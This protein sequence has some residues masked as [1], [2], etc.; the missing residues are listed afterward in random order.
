MA[1]RMGA[2]GILLAC[3]CLALV[4]LTCA[5]APTEPPPSVEQQARDLTATPTS[6]R[7]RTPTRTY[8]PRASFTPAPT[9]TATPIPDWPVQ[10]C[11]DLAV[12]VN[13]SLTEWSAVTPVVLNVANAAAVVL[14]PSVRAT[15]TPVP[16]LTPWV[17]T[18]TPTLTPVATATTRPTN[19]PAPAVADFSGLFYCAH[20]GAG[21]LYLAGTF[22][23]TDINAPVGLLSNGDAAEITLDM[24][25]DGFRMPRVDDH[26]ISI[27]PDWRMLNFGAYPIAGTL[28]IGT[29]SGLWRFELAL[30]ATSYGRAG[31]IAPGDTFGVTWT[32]YDNRGGA[33][34]AYRLTSAK[35]RATL[36]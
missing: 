25:A 26:I 4:L 24:A 23:D 36:Q 34:W 5:P 8:T 7:T 9:H 16:T 10:N 31:M 11:P 14:A 35:R 1:R 17:G 27:A 19:T 21:T 20:D 33:T 30:P 32:Y 12:T 22:S 13:G 2:I 29:A 18:G 6:T 15:W 3:G 28:A